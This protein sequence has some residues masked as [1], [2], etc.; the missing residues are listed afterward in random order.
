M[1]EEKDIFDFDSIEKMGMEESMIIEFTKDEF[2]NKARSVLN[3]ILDLYTQ[4]W[5]SRILSEDESEIAPCEGCKGDGCF[6]FKDEEVNCIQDK[7]EGE[8][9]ER[10]FDED[11]FISG[12]TDDIIFGPAPFMELLAA[13][14]KD[15]Q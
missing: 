4:S 13:N 15:L 8:C 11:G 2:I 5:Y 9:Y 6:L 10:L 14:I 1:E 12:M 3:S 7:E